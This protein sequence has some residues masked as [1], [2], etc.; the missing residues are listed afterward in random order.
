M[1]QRD[2]LRQALDACAER[3]ESLNRT[4]PELAS[5]ASHSAV[6]QWHQTKVSLGLN[7]GTSGEPE[8]RE[9][10]SGDSLSEARKLAIALLEG[11]GLEE[12]QDVLQTELAL[13]LSM[14]MLV[15]LIGNTAYRDALK[16]DG[17]L[18]QQN[19]ISYE[20]IANLW[21]DLERPAFGATEWNAR[22]ISVLLS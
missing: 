13:T 16:Q 15:R 21:N 19:A 1:E 22:S 17:G 14:P 7:P 2:R 12:V 11:N 9:T 5:P 10:I 3:L 4:Y 20:Q 18:M 6:E 8:S